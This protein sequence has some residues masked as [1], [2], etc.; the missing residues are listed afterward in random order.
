VNILIATGDTPPGRRL[1]PLPFNSLFGSLSLIMEKGRP[2]NILIA[3]GDTPPGRRLTPL[4]LSFD[5]LPLLTN[6]GT[7]SLGMGRPV[8][9]LI[10]T[11]DTPPGRRLTPL[12]LEVGFLASSANAEAATIIA[13]TN[14]IAINIFF[15]F[16]LLL[17]IY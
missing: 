3:T 1:T 9:I 13:N 11:G 17:G 12:K 7:P 5:S 16:H 15:I 8:N 10:A 4:P 2:V 14:N 6:A